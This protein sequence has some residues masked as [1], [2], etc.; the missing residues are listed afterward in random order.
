M[1]FTLSSDQEALQE[2]VRKLCEGRFPME[3]VRA[4]A[5]VGGVDRALWRE[6]ADA[7][8]FSLRLA[9]A[10]GGA[11]LGTAE[12]VL[13]FEELG[14]ALVPGPLVWTH[15]AAGVIAGA[16]EG[17]RVVGG[18][19]RWEEPLLVEHLD[20]ID[21]LLAVDDDGLWE[22]DRSRLS[23]RSVSWPL[24]PLTPVHV[25]GGLLRGQRRGVPGDAVRWRLEGAV[26]TA[27][28]QL[29]MAAVLTEMSVAYAKERQ[30]FDRPIG[31]FQAI[32]HLLADMFVRT[33]V[34]RSAVYAAAVN[35]DQPALGPPARAVAGA[36]L[37]AGEAAT[38]NAKTATQVHGGMGFT[39][40]VD[41]HLYLKRSWVLDTAFGTAET[42]AD[43]VASLLGE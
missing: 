35:L 24:D 3:R 27:A 32:K 18:L 36:K 29:G 39:W 21:V 1:D 37:L 16:A 2:A 6:L 43:T 26:L 20:A 9:E 41:V 23:A 8:V 33:E 19:Q 10:D 7:G 13:V 25:A 34:A 5:D 40:E 42:H 31:S 15:L 14:R 4:L 12:A 22:A 38:V 11:D 17:E 28:F 30:Q